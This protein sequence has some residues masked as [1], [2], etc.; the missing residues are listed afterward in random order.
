MRTEENVVNHG[1]ARSELAAHS[2]MYQFQ[3]CHRQEPSCHAPLVG[4]HD[5]AEPSAVEQRNRLGHSWEK[6]QLFPSSHILALRG[7]TIDNPITIQKHG[8]FHGILPAPPT[9][10]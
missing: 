10:R 9:L 4:Y 1:S 8:S 7:R 2:L 6:L 3:R 5:N